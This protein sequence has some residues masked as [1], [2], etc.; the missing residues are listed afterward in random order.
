V[1]FSR[2]KHRS[3]AARAWAAFIDRNT[4]AVR[5]AGL[6]EAVTASVARWDDFL[7]HGRLEHHDDPTAF[8]IDQLSESQYA[9]LTLLV[10][11]YFVAGYEFF[12][13]EALRIEDQRAL[14]ARFGPQGT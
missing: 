7:M 5:A 9:A 4:S 8:A 1:G 2:W 14:R 10:E 11:S 12:T 6:P 3:Q 13:P